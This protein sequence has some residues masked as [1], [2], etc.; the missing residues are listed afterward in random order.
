MVTPPTLTK[1]REEAARIITEAHDDRDPLLIANLRIGI[2]GID[3][4]P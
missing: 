1:V 3:D 4:D 2:L